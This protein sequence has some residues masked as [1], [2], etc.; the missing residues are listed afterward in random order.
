MNK[1][2]IVIFD[3]ETGSKDPSSCQL[4]QIGALVVH[5]RSLK[6]VD[7]FNQQC[8]PEFD[9][10]KA[11]ALGLAPVEQEALN[12]T[13]KTKE[14]LLQQPSERIVF[15]KF[16]GFLKK[17]TFG[18]GSYGAPIPCGYN[19]I[20][21]DLKIVNRLQTM[22]KVKHLFNGLNKIDFYDIFWF[23]TEN[24]PEIEARKLSNAGEW[25]GLPQE[26]MANTHD[27]MVDVRITANCI[28][29]MLHFTREMAKKTQFQKAFAGGQ[30]LA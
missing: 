17:Y 14:D 28:L 24:N 26:M 13:R 18:T 21:F 12:V 9:D 30:L 11:I 8:C 10:E 29:K 1:N 19:I 20:N 23:W 3:F 2:Y 15:E 22:Y 27:A 16:V 25:M 5:P 4:T 7:Q 6:V